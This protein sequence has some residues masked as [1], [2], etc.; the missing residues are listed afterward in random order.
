MDLFFSAIQIFG[1]ST[2]KRFGK[3]LGGRLYTMNEAYLISNL[4]TSDDTSIV[5]STSLK[6][7]SNRSS[8]N[9]ASGRYVPS[10]AINHRYRRQIFSLRNKR[11]DKNKKCLANAALRW[12]SI[13]IKSN[14]CGRT[15]ASK[16]NRSRKAHRA[17]IPPDRAAIYVHSIQRESENNPRARSV[18]RS[19]RLRHGRARLRKTRAYAYTSTWT[20]TSN[21]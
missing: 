4:N 1:R 17:R 19:Q 8:V 2:N 5:L 13:K 12:L 14:P 6:I 15:A 16:E 10:T 18:S 11:S 20:C 21:R 3:C 7:G 9:R